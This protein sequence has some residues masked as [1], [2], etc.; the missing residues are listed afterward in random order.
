L[1]RQSNSAEFI[2]GGDRR[3]TEW[4][5]ATFDPSGRWLFVNLQSPVITLAITGPWERG[6]L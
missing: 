5:G 6:L 1:V 3:E 4:A 2:A